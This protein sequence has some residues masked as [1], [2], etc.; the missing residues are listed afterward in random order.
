MRFA[1]SGIDTPGRKRLAQQLS[2]ELSW[3]FLEKRIDEW[4]KSNFFLPVYPENM[5][6]SVFLKMHEDVMFD[7]IW[8]E[9]HWPDYV[10][11]GITIENG[12][13]VLSRYVKEERLK[14]NAPER[15]Y[16]NDV[17]R[18]YEY[19]SLHAQKTYD[20]IALVLP[21]GL[22]NGHQIKF[23]ETLSLALQRMKEKVYTVRS[24]KLGDQMDEILWHIA[25]KTKFSSSAVVPK[26]C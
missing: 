7:K 10:S 19:A 4:I 15:I 8:K 2:H 11:E 26:E 25:K 18:F 13:E 6:I 3:L 23:F 1:I 5:P 16:I 9:T 20:L 24:E 22:D 17:R 21:N 14:G 12:I